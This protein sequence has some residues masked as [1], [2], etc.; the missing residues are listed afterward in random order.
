MSRKKSEFLGGFGMANEILKAIIDAVLEQGG[1]DE[2][3]RRIISAPDLAKEI[4]GLIVQKQNNT[5]KVVVD[6]SMSLADMIATGNYAWKNDD[7]TS[8]HF[9]VSGTGVVTIELEIVHLDGYFRTA[10]VMGHLNANGLRPADVKEFSTYIS[11][12]QVWRCLAS[13][14]LRP[15][16]IEELLAFGATFPKVQL[17]HAVI[18]FASVWRDS[19]GESYLPYLTCGRR[20]FDLV[21][22]NEIW[23]DE[24]RFLAVHK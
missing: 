23:S 17:E 19:Y 9:P 11:S 18:C 12:E 22:Y 13:R 10:E 7:V 2:D 16:R 4:A 3:L 14:G 15:A 6:Y 8:E 1:S 24:C 5:Y 20:G 21:R